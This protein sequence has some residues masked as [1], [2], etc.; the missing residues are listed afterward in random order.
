MTHGSHIP[1]GAKTVN[2]RSG[3]SD[4][5][6]LSCFCFY[7]QIECQKLGFYSDLEQNFLLPTLWVIP[8][9]LL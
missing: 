9:L 4:L 5:F 8:F 2:I 6:S 1:A 7:L 3:E